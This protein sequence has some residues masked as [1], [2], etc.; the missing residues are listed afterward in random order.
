M[1]LNDTTPLI[2]KIFR[3]LSDECYFY[4]E[5]FASHWFP[6]FSQLIDADASPIFMGSSFYRIPNRDAREILHK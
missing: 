5:V 1:S 2:K 4:G 3:N 6:N